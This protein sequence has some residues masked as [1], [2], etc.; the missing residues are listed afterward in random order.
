MKI[1]FVGIGVGLALCAWI[2][3]AGLSEDWEGGDTAGWKQQFP[4]AAAAL[5][6]PGGYLRL[7]FAGG[8]SLVPAEPAAAMADADSNIDMGDYGEIQRISFVLLSEGTVPG[9]LRVLLGSG[10]REWT[11]NAIDIAG[12]TGGAGETTVVSVPVDYNAGGWTALGSYNNAEAFNETLGDVEWVSV[13]FEKNGPGAQSYGIDD[14]TLVAAVDGGA[15]AAALER[16]SL[17][18]GATADG[19][20]RITWSATGGDGSAAFE[21]W[22]STDLTQPEL[23]VLLGVDVM[24]NGDGVY[25]F[26]DPEAADLGACFYKIK[27]K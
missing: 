13:L 22:R 7:A 18:M 10:T 20:M 4:S 19:A 23:W 2:G 16:S 21:V 11:Y 1:G 17:R 15:P 3:N 6:N 5:S 9:R 25:V 26:E 12:L 8:S 27:V 14:F 24:P